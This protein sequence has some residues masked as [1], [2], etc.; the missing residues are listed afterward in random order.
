[1][2]APCPACG[3][4]ITAPSHP[5][6]PAE[7]P[8]TTRGDRIRKSSSSRSKGHVVADSAI[9]YQHLDRKET[10][11]ALRIFLLFVLTICACLL[12]TWFMKDWIR[13]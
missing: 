2:T 11:K 8:A 4:S 9:D 10:A 6:T 3:S 1:M 13:R 5:A 7:L 12:V